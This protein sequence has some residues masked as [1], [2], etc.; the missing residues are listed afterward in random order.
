[1]PKQATRK[2]SERIRT[3]HLQQLQKPDYDRDGEKIPAKYTPTLPRAHSHER[4]ACE[5]FEHLEKHTDTHGHSFTSTHSDTI[6]DCRFLFYCH[7]PFGRCAT[8]GGNPVCVCV[9]GWKGAMCEIMV[10]QEFLQDVLYLDITNDSQTLEEKVL[11]QVNGQPS[12]AWTGYDRPVST[13]KTSWPWARYHHSAAIIDN[14]LIIYGGFS[15]QCK[16]FCADTWEF[17]LLSP[18]SSWYDVNLNMLKN[19][20]NWTDQALHPGERYAEEV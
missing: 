14:I 13:P 4:L 6:F 10:D 5:R 15:L 19:T 8:D 12:V 2:Q 1:M 11:A 18:N 3:A 20:A 16:D 17:N 9:D 7:Y